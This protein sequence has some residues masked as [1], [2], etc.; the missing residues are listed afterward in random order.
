MRFAEDDQNLGFP[1]PHAPPE[2]PAGG[3]PGPPPLDPLLARV[4]AP[5]PPASPPPAGPT[6]FVVPPFE[7]DRLNKG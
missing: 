4:L 6:R 1:A 3:G 2:P 7:E 5:Q